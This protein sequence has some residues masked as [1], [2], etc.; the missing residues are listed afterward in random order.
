MEATLHVP[1]KESEQK[2]L[3]FYIST[4]GIVLFLS[5]FL[6]RTT[7]KAEIKPNNLTFFL[8]PLLFPHKH[9]GRCSY[10]SQTTVILKGQ[11]SEKEANL[12]LLGIARKRGFWCG[13]SCFRDKDWA[14]IL[15]ASLP[16][17]ALK[18]IRSKILPNAVH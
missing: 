8:F 9:P 13:C 11:T 17:Y 3:A 5:L 18:C 12:Q 4:S 10:H 6:I 1:K 16:C 7:Q 15:G 2:L 14:I